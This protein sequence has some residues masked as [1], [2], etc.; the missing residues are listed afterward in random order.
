MTTVFDEFKRRRLA[1]MLQ[2]R[3]PIL[4]ESLVIA[5]GALS[6]GTD[7]HTWQSSLGRSNSTSSLIVLIIIIH[8]WFLCML[9]SFHLRMQL[10]LKI[11][12]VEFED[13]PIIFIKQDG[14]LSPT[15]RASAGYSLRPWDHRG[16][17]YMDRKRIQCL[18]NASQH[19]PIYLQPFS[20]NSS[21]KIQSSQF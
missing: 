17:C 10:V 13:R 8:T 11:K 12:Y 18:S 5:T 1:R 3:R 19:V 20:H 9:K 7:K 15:E 2:C 16:K 4:S 21:R 14:W 6:T